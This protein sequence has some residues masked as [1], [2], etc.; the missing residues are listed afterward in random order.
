MRATDS[1]KFEN[2]SASTENFELK[3]GV[4]QMACVAAVYGTVRISQ[5][6]PDG[7]TY[8]S[9]TAAHSANGVLLASLPPG[10][11]RVTIVGASGVYFS[12]ARIPEPAL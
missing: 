3:G 12:I 11:Y 2:I 7:V 1:V 5:L 10:Q 8:G 6:L 9:P 4:Y